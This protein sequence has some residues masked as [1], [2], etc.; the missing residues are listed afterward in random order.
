MKVV[1]NGSQITISLEK[2]ESHIDVEYIE[3]SFKH[4]D[5]LK[6]YRKGYSQKRKIKLNAVREALEKRGVD[7]KAIEK[8]AL[9]S[10]G[11]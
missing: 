4:W 10:L 7:V 11:V 2:D 5:Y 6:T 8:E 9:E 3:K 1:K